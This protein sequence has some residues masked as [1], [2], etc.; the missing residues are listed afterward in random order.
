MVPGKHRLDS[1]PP[2]KFKKRK[3]KSLIEGSGADVL[4][5]EVESLIRTNGNVEKQESSAVQVDIDSLSFSRF[6]ETEVNIQELSSSGIPLLVV[7][8]DYQ[9]TA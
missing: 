9:E 2:L 7:T 4:Q 1:K 5:W 8:D 3:T 6:D